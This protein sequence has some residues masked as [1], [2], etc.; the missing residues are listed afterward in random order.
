MD[1]TRSIAV[2][3]TSD[4]PWYKDINKYQWKC[5]IAAGLGYGL[6]AMDM[7]LYAMII[8]QVMKELGM[9]PAM[10][11][12]IASL[13]LF[14][15]AFGGLVFGIYAD[16]KGRT[17]S[18]VISILMYSVF[19][20]LCGFSQTV[21]QLAVFR[22]LV[23]IGLGGE[24]TAG[25][26]LIT[27]TWPAKHRGKAM[28]FVQ[29]NFGVGYALAAV[30]TMIVLPQWGWRAVFF[31]GA[32]PALVTFFIRRN[33]KEPEIWIKNKEEGQH[34][35][36]AETFRIL[37]NKQYASKTIITT[38]ICSFT[39]F[40][41]WGAFTWIPSYLAMPIEKGGAGLSI[42]KGLTFIIIM[43]CGGVIGHLTF[44]AISDKIGRKIS[45]V[46][47]F[48]MSAILTVAYGL[49]RDATI[50]LIMGPVLAYFGYGYYASFGVILAET[51]PTQVRASGTG[52]AY[53]VGRAVSSFGPAVVGALAMQ[54]GVGAGIAIT[55]V[56][57]L[58]ATGFV[59]MLPETK[60]K[61]LD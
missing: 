13:S 5:F 60:G 27:E 22:T 16:K 26:A 15:A 36:T 11:G 32:L 28:G 9:N 4:G 48:I 55:A 47:F 56:A 31:V 44:G 12:F 38:L 24:Y 29:A 2:S 50:L 52:F 51:F 18:M 39:L 19:T 10:G 57:Y 53:N 3:S 21:M 54:F 35:G 43:Q 45:C 17:K 34:V 1:A 23:G 7:M 25:A 20:M 42:V 61:I 40:A 6:E 41:Y 59:L 14:S 49:T 58:F 30:V 33:I 37:F 8:V 46:I